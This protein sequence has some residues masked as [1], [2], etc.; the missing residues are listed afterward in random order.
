[1]PILPVC[2]N[3]GSGILVSAG[4]LCIKLKWRHGKIGLG[5]LSLIGRASNSGPLKIHQL[6]PLVPAGQNKIDKAMSL[7][8]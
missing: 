7:G 5:T 1:M 3:G 4:S 6:I 2:Q 8:M